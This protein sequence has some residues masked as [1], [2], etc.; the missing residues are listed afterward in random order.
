MKDLKLECESY[1]T[2]YELY[3]KE[4][5]YKKTPNGMR[6]FVLKAFLYNNGLSETITMQE[7]RAKVKEL[8]PNRMDGGNRTYYSMLLRA[9]KENKQAQQQTIERAKALEQEKNNY[10]INRS[11]ELSALTS[12]LY[13][14]GLVLEYEQEHPFKYDD[15]YRNDLSRLIQDI[16][17][18]QD[19]KG[20]TNTLRIT[21]NGAYDR[22]YVLTDKDTMRIT[23]T[24]I[25]T[26]NK[27]IN[28][29]NKRGQDK[30]NK[31]DKEW[32]LRAF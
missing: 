26:I 23:N 12:Y 13:S 20:Q 16:K 29:T 11:D 5:K 25:A 17:N 3:M 30:W 10:I 27:L 22:Y 19:V 24:D 21:I 15:D 1:I 32:V 18:N 31:K 28:K 9:L 6:V 14:L 7:F 8:Y 2:R 4:N